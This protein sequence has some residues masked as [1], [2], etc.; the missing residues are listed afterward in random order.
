MGATLLYTIVPLP[1]TKSKRVTLANVAQRAG[2]SVA[3]ASVAITGRASGNCRV[4]VAVAEKIRAVAHEMRYRPNLQARNLSTQRTR[5][6]ALLIKRST[7]HNAAFYLTACQRTLRAFG[8]EEMVML[9]P[10]DTLQSER[11]HLELC[12]ERQVEGIIATPLIDLGGHANVE[13]FNRIHQEDKIPVV[14]LGLA[15]EGCVA[16]SVTV[17][18]TG[19]VR[20]A[21]TLLHAMGHRRIA[22]CTIPGYE[23]AAPLNPFRAAHLRYRGYQTAMAELKLHQQLF[24]PPQRCT[25]VTMLFDA[26]CELGRQIADANPR[27]TAIIAFSDFVGAGLIAGLIDLN[28]PVPGE[29]SV[30]SIGDQPFTKILRPTMSTILQQGEKMGEVASTMLLKMIDGAPGTSTSLM[31]ALSLRESVRELAS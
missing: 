31:P 23:D 5:T 3:T 29:I 4:S 11:D 8:F 16:P 22:H 20:R 2:V 28:I 14:Q 18:E 30:L 26:A 17:D 10:D 9:H 6:I 21:V 24:I 12:V 13:L 25:H 19:G 1:R 7:W 15:L 27:P